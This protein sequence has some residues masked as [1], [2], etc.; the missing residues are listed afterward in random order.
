MFNLEQAIADWRQKMLAAGI[1]SPVPLEELELHLREEIDRLTHAGQEPQ[2]AFEAATQQIG[3]AGSLN[4]E[5]SKINP[6][7]PMKSSIK[8]MSGGMALIGMVMIFNAM[9]EVL[10]ELAKLTQDLKTSPELIANLMLDTV[11]TTSAVG[12]F[13]A[14]LVTL[15]L[16]S[17]IRPPVLSAN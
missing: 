3:P 5:F 11:L 12:V 7:P 2:Q 10:P 9:G 14:A 8:I 6:Q 17:T 13:L 4:L 1:E 16:P 15:F